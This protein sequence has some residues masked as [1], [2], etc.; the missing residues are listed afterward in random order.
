V[1]EDR[2]HADTSPVAYPMYHFLLNNRAIR[3]FGIQRTN[4]EKFGDS[5][6]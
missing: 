4:D 1:Q 6:F 2:R 3:L 5:V